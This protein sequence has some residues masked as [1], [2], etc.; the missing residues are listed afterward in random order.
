MENNK[1]NNT[2]EQKVLT[3][4]VLDDKSIPTE[5]ASVSISPSDDSGL[6]NSAGEIEFKLGIATKYNITASY[7]SKEVT[8]P[9]YVTKDGATRLVVNPTY[10]RSVEKK[11]HPYALENID[12][13]LIRYAGVGLGVGI[14]LVIIWKIFKRK[15]RK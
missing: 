2:I 15:R 8:V 7:G 1:N 14:L 5:G 13:A 12:P 3:V 9:Y 11:L 10:V 4:V 6:T